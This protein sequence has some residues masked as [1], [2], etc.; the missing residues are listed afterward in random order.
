LGVIDVARREF[1]LRVPDDL[2]VI[3]FDDIP[4]AEYD[5]YRLTTLRQDTRGLALAA[6]DLLADRLQTFD[7]PSRTR[8]VPVMQAVRN[9]CASRRR[10]GRGHPARHF[11]PPANPRNR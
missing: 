10:T 3:G 2:R 5:A 9:S 6:I 4:A 8:V 11:N 7:G 1:G